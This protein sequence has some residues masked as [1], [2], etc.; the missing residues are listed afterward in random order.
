MKNEQIESINIELSTEQSKALLYL[1]SPLHKDVNRI[2]FGGA[3]GGGKSFLIC[4]WLDYMANTYPE[5]RYYMARETLKDVKDSVLLT[6]F[7]VMAKFGRRYVYSEQ[8]NRIIYPLT[9]STIYLLEAFAYPSDP[10][11]QSLGSREYTAGAIEEGITITKRAADILISRTR[12]KHD[13]YADLSP[14]QLI[15]CNPG[16]GWIKDEIVIP[17]INGVILKKNVLFIPAS[18]DSNP[19]AEFSK[20]YRKT[21]E[22]NLS[23]FDRLRLLEGN[24]DAQ[25]KTG[26]EY[27]KE[28]NPEMHTGIVEYDNQLPLHVTFDENVNPHITCLIYQNFTL[29]NGLR[30]IRQIAEV[31]P[32][33]PNNTRKYVCIKVMQLF[34]GHTAGCFVYG[35]STSKK[36]ETSKEKGE[37]FFTDIMLYLQPLRPSLRVPTKNPAVISKGGFMNLIFEKEYQML[38]IIISKECKGT[39]S[40]FAYALENSEGGILKKKVTDPETGIQYEKHG[41]FIDASSYFLTVCFVNEFANYLNGGNNPTYEMGR[42]RD[43][44]FN[45]DND[46]D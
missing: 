34:P 28:F 24:W 35:D 40:D 11:F 19:N 12:Y 44:S 7:D 36:Q 8:R 20:R 16:N 10:D 39:I 23:T 18:L 1:T 2:I 38:K 21:L 25:Q 29:P 14:K 4:A 32:K 31:C 46:F 17:Q 3:A 22:E 37:N 30:E 26:A 27:L 45:R 41:H 6:Y 43:Y 42:D 13:V 15:T 5:T 9:G 33:S